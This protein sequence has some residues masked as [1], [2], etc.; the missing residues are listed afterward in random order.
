MPEKRVSPEE[1]DRYKRW[2]LLKFRE[3]LRGARITEQIQRFASGEMGADYRFK[4]DIVLN[5]EARQ[6]VENP[7]NKEKLEQQKLD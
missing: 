3:M 2:A 5:A 6:F 1:I 4:V 7:A